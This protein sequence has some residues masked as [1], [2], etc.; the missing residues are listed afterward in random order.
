LRKNLKFHDAQVAD[1]VATMNNL[2]F[3]QGAFAGGFFAGDNF[4]SSYWGISLLMIS[5]GNSISN[6]NLGRGYGGNYA[7]FTI[8]VRTGAT[9]AFDKNYLQEEEME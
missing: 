1:D 6:S 2:I 9:A 4:L 8:K 3:N 5:G 7:S